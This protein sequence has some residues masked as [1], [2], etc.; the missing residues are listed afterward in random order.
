MLLSF[1]LLMDPLATGLYLHEWAGLLI[2]ILFIVHKLINW[3]WI[4]KTTKNF[5][6]KMP[7]RNRVLYVIDWLLLIGFTLV[8]ISGIKIAHLIDFSWLGVGRGSVFWRLGHM[9]FS[10]LCLILVAIH[11]G[12]NW[13]WVLNRFSKNNTKVVT[14]KLSK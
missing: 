9:S 14:E 7:Q 12:L 10:I 3:I 2:C 11:V 13:K 1:L 5:F 6:R 4:K 8:V